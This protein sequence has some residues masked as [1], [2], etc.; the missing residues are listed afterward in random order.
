[1]CVQ[2]V[3]KRRDLRADEN[4]QVLMLWRKFSVSVTR[5]LHSFVRSFVRSDGLVSLL[6]TGS[7]QKKNCRV[8]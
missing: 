7:K 8:R 1:V 6:Y 4:A 5:R 2:R 3:V